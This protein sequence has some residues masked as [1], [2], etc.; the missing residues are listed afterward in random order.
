[1]KAVADSLPR[2][3][4]ALSIRM[5]GWIAVASMLAVA[6]IGPSAGGVAAAAGSIWTT[7]ITCQS[8]AP[9]DENHYKV[10]DIVHVRGEG[11]DATTTYTYTVTGNPGNSSSDPGI[12]V[13]T[14]PVTTNASGEFCVA[15]YTVLPGDRGEYTVDVGTKNDNFQVD[16][17]PSSPPSEAPSNPPSVPAS[18]EP[19]VPASVPASNPPSGGVVEATGTPGITPPSTA[20]D[21]GS[22][23][24]TSNGWLIPILGIALLLSSLLLLTP[25]R[26]VRRRR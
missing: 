7:H 5:L 26:T 25:S 13:A 6:L 23:G 4:G 21:V 8:P 12:V 19:S 1:M 15:A 16:E 22:T 2:R 3:K 18:E 11:F 10:G 17:E 9:Q 14:G 24:S 20:T